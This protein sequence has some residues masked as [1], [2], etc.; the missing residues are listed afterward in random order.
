MLTRR[1]AFNAVGPLD[2]QYFLHCEDLDWCARFA[3]AGWSIL[4]VPHL[5]IRH[6]QGGCSQSRPQFVLWHKHRGMLIYYRKFLGP[7]HPALL[8]GLVVIGIGARWL[9]LASRQWLRGLVALRAGS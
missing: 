5:S 6:H 3:A 4:Y 7:G 1:A 2:E 8:R 9:W